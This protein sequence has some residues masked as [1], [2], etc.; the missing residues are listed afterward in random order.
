MNF[1]ALK[2][3]LSIHSLVRE[4]L[5]DGKVSGNEYVCASI[6]GGKGK[7]FSVNLKTGVW[8]EFNG[9][10]KGGDIIS[11][12]AAVKGVSQKEAYL[13]LG[14]EPDSAPTLKHPQ[15]GLPS[16]SW[17][18]L[19]RSG[20]PLMYVARYETPDGKTFLPWTANDRG[21]HCK[22]LPAPRPLYGL[23]LLDSRLHA[24]IL[25][26]EGEKACDAARLLAPNFVV[27]TWPHGAK[28]INHVDWTPLFRRPVVVLWPDADEAGIKAMSE[29]SKI[30]LPSCP[31]VKILSPTN[32]PVGWDAADA[33]AEGFT[34]EQLYEWIDK[35]PEVV[36]PKPKF[37]LQSVEFLLAQPEPVLEWLIEGLWTAHAKGLLVGQ[38]NLGKTWIALDMLI[39]FV[40]GLPCLGRFI[41]A[42]TGNALLIEQEGSM[43]NLNRR[44]HMLAKGRGLSPESF[45]RLYHMS[46]QFPKV[47]GNEPE[48]IALI[49]SQAIEF[50]VFDSLVRFHD[51]DEN[52][53]SEM[54][55]VLESF[56]RINI[57]TGAAVLLIHH[58][59]KSG[60]SKRGIWERV[61]GTSDLVAWRDCLL[62][63]QGEE[64]SDTVTCSFQFRDAENP[65]PIQ[66]QR[67]LDK[68]INSVVMKTVSFDETDEFKDKLEKVY[69]VIRVHFG[70]AT[71]E[72]IWKGLGGS[73]NKAWKFIEFLEARHLIVKNGLK[74]TVP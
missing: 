53:A 74:W 30:L 10:L 40:S 18:Y 9:D 47:P 25:L 28:G 56:T 31:S 58:L 23:D 63:L 57:E 16:M 7:S 13:A 49:K 41:P 26:V 67:I 32:R 64:G 61:R 5:P 62:G 14:G 71:K 48:L 45:R 27:L 72:E 42:R 24:P 51:K 59:G 33:V 4:L 54:R 39:S 36:A 35:T 2:T 65:A 22:S 19:S 38:P 60:D 17:R 55:M 70:E 69:S 29:I 8:A 73:R 1:E 66:I 11:L 44:F 43:A 50:V 52:S 34:T 37:H 3:K 46:F 21:W 12:Y 6:Q 15:F 68:E 20:I